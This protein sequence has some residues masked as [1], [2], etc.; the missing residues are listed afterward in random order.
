MNKKKKKRNAHSDREW[1]KSIIASPVASN[2]DQKKDRDLSNMGVMKLTS[3]VNWFF[4]SF[5][6]IAERVSS[7][8]PF[9]SINLSF[10]LRSSNSFG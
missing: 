7:K 4:S 2:H 9:S 3:F 10:R 6:L 1:R 8:S 5:A